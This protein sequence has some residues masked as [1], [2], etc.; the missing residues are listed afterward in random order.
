MDTLL[1]IKALIMGVVE[2]LTEF[3]PV[4]STGH[5]IVV[6]SLLNLESPK[7]PVFGI[8]IQSGAIFA[9]MWLYRQKISTLVSSACF[10]QGQEAHN[11]RRLIKNVAIAFIP[12][13]VLGLLFGKSIQDHLFT[14]EVVA[15]AFIVGGVAILWLEAWYQRI[16]PQ[17]KA[18]AQE[19]SLETMRTKDALVVGLCQC[20]AL[21]PGTSR[22]GASIMGGIVGGL[23][24]VA[25]VEFSFF[26]A[27]PTLLV[28]GLYSLY[29]ARDLLTLADLPFFA[30]GFMAAFFSAWVSVRWLLRYISTHSFVAFAWY[31]IVVGCFIL[32]IPSF[33][34]LT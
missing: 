10:S 14:T 33:K 21:V 24:R 15:T 6:G 22:S 30:V 9:L 8:S 34:T 18:K 31:R 12:A 2:G 28:A 1:L 13:G 4:S 20:L 27:M 25:A 23:N 7:G 3:L 11:A 16:H 26:L 32:F 19:G 17:R 5:L 29:K